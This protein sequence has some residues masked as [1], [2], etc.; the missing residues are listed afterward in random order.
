MTFLPRRALPT[1][2]LP[3]RALLLVP[4]L[5][6]IV[7]LSSCA[8][9]PADTSRQYLLP[10]A[11]E[12]PTANASLPDLQLHLA[13]YLDQ[14]GIVLQDGPV[15][16]TAARQHRWADPLADQLRRSLRYHLSE[17]GVAAQGRLIVDVVQFQGSNDG[18][19]LVA[20]HWQFDNNKGGEQ[21]GQFQIRQPLN[22]DGYGA[23]VK[24][25][26][27]AWATV[28]QSISEQL[29]K[30]QASEEK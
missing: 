12:P 5:A 10:G 26:D 17:D 15:T 14:G 30:P 19:A 20:G 2:V 29:Q 16:V 6:I 27:T 13:G 24:Q 9:V 3:K 4:L 8:S 22:Q 7:L 28:A 21:S 11:A 18:H 23:L 1:R 25:L